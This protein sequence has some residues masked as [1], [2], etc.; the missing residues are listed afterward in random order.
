MKTSP[1]THGHSLCA[2]TGLLFLLVFSLAM[3]SVVAAQGQTAI[4]GVARDTT[5]AVLPG[6]TVE[7]AGPAI[8]EGSRLAITDANGQY[9]IVDLRPGTY[10]VVFRLQGFSTLRREG[11]VLTANFVAPVN[12]EMQVSA[13]EETVTVRGESP[14]VDVVSSTREEVLSREQLDALP[15]G[16]DFT[17]MGNALPS[18]NMGRFDVGG[19]STNQQGTLT[20]FGGRGEDL[21][22]Q[23]D[24]MNG[25]NAGWGDHHLPQRSG[26]PGD[27]LLDR[28]L[29]RREPHRRRRDQHDP[30]RRRQRAPRQL[31]PDICERRHAGEQPRR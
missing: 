12:A 10:T 27:G 13:V 20:A 9:R 5:G 11:L 22:V 6:V 24:G 30:A 18:V 31:C 29:E 19:S 14:I 21:N 25:A 2:W 23:V 16:R 8:I 1:R 4:A 7:V 15:T 28:R 17:T 3:P 26:L